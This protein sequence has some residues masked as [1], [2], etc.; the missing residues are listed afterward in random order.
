[1]KSSR[2]EILGVP[3]RI[4]LYDD[5]SSPALDLEEIRSYLHENTGAS[6]ESRPEFFSHQ[7]G[8]DLEALA[9]SVTKTRVRNPRGEPEE[10]EPLLGEVDFELRMLRDPRKRLPGILYDGFRFQNALRALL[11]QE[12]RSWRTMHLAFT[13][14]LVG[15]FDPADRLYHA[16]VIVCGYPSIISTSG[17]VE[18][19]AKPREFYLVRRGYSALGLTPPTDTLK[20]ELRGRFIDYDDERTTEV[21][22]GY[23]LQAFFYHA[24]GDPFCSNPDCRLFNAHWQEEMIQSQLSSGELCEQHRSLLKGLKDAVGSKEI[25]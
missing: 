3:E 13:S 15:T 20:E 11:A 23:V 10:F 19:P 24:T 25:G 22:K 12:E 5:P 16:R 18:G 1:M 8:E 4:L 17:L 7:R 6:V 14:R 2:S 9:R 21:L